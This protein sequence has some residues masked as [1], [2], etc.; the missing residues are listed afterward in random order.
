M[1]DSTGNQL[2]IVYFATLREAFGTA[3]RTIDSTGIRTVSDL[4][5]KHPPLPENTLIAVNQCYADSDTPVNSGDEV[6]FF[7]PVTGG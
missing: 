4:L 2:R 1:S 3:G 7:P 5:A 6:A